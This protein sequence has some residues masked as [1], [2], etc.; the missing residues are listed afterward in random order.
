MRK[1]IMLI[2]L[3]IGISL[4]WS[5]ATPI[6]E[7]PDEQAHIGT[8]EFLL[9]NN[10]VPAGEEYDM[11]PEMQTT[12]KLLGVFRD[13]Y[14][15]NSITYH[16][17]YRVPYTNALTG[18]YEEQIVALNNP[19]SRGE[20]IWKEA[21]RYPR[22]YYDFV[23]LGDRLVHDSDIFTRV[24]VM[25]LV[26]LTLFVATILVAY[27]FGRLFFHKKYLSLTL[28]LMVLLQPMYTFLSAGVNSDNLHNLLVACILT[29]GVYHLKYGPTVVS[30][31]FSLLVLGLDLLT[32][33]Q[34]FIVIPILALS[35]LPFLLK[36]KLST[37]S[38][39]ILLL[40]TL[41]AIVYTQSLWSPYISLLNS[42]NMHGV[43]FNSFLSFSVNKL[44][45]QNIVWYWGVFKWLGVVLPPLY[46]QL[47]NRLVLL[48]GV[49]LLFYFYKVLKGK[50]VM[51]ALLPTLYL[52]FSTVL[53]VG[54]IYWF[55]WQ[56][57]KDVGYSLGIQ[58]RYFF[59][60]ILP[61][62]ALM[63]L[64]LMSFGWSKYTR[65][66]LALALTFFFLWLQLG[67]IWRLLTSYYDVSSLSTFVTQ[68]SQYKPV[69][70]KG[71]WWYLYLGFYVLS[72]LTIFVSALR[73][74]K[75]KA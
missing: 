8:V 18:L 62:M 11:T 28:A 27:H 45:S 48:S 15:N 71:N 24:F 29:L 23:G 2:V 59:P 75:Y 65:R 57:H 58:A 38:K 37:S 69:F 22:L 25:R 20:Y 6:F 66:L 30:T 44:I 56:Y 51:S 17:E 3:T 39:L 49:G 73:R 72:C 54:A 47:A 55:D 12:Q 41:V 70:A 14:G 33:P 36:Q 7:F 35:Y 60:V 64:G 32:K 1:I 63:L 68:V 52:I 9:K 40:Y 67:G 21:A 19:E 42:P 10:R 5:F 4:F 74:A 13:P 34:G 53:Y 46:W 16:P 61:Q 43:S 26:N 50:K 31:L